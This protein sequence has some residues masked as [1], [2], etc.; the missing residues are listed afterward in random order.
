MKI[1][2]K[3][4]TF[5]GLDI[6]KYA[7]KFVEFSFQK[8]KIS[9]SNLGHSCL[10]FETIVDEM[11]INTNEIIDR[12][13]TIISY[14]KLKKNSTAFS[15]PGNDTII[16]RIQV[17]GE[18]FDDI[19]RG[20]E[21]EAPNHIPYNINEIKIAFH[22]FEQ[23][24]ESEQND[25]LLIAVKEEI[26]DDYLTILIESGLKPEVADI[27][28][29][30][31]QNIF[32]YNYKED[33]DPAETVALINIGANLLNIL[34]LKN[35]Q[36]LFYRDTIL[37]NF[38]P[39][40]RI[41]NT[42][43]LPYSEIEKMKIENNP[44]PHIQNFISSINKNITSNIAKGLDLYLSSTNEDK[45]DK[46]FL[47]GGGALNKDIKRFLKSRYSGSEIGYL[48]PFKN[49]EIDEKLFDKDYINYIKP[50]FA[51][52]AGLALRGMDE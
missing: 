45:I 19:Q 35:F 17:K 50:Q 41:Q 47:S 23:E 13:K 7:V 1:L 4:K 16:K 25:I 15:I 6:G 8:E 39:Y 31:I 40:E 30:A 18:T 52:A 5:I 24:E 28:F 44:N 48:D 51:V 26:L 21:L 3:A 12:I 22:I 11:L 46:I 27:D 9:L 33:I 2:K 38:L 49:V 29:F 42:L 43:N 32:E 10:S 36:S 34:I 20:V 14:Y 37:G